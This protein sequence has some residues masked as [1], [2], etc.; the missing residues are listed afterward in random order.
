MA[1]FKSPI[2]YAYWDNHDGTKAMVEQQ[3]VVQIN[4][5]QDDLRYH[6]DMFYL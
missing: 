1:E 5:K 6:E 4:I 2:G 3:V